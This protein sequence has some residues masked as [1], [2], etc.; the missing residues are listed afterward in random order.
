ML[1]TSTSIGHRATLSSYSN[2]ICVLLLNIC[3]FFQLRFRLH[4]LLRKLAG[5]ISSWSAPQTAAF[6]NVK[7]PTKAIGRVH[8]FK[9]SFCLLHV[10]LTCWSPPE[11][12]VKYLYT[13]C[14]KSNKLTDPTSCQGKLDRKEPEMEKW[15]LSGYINVVP[16]E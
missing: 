10:C 12:L 9:C 16:K 3:S 6:L 13:Q 11:E 4:Q 7:Y 1:P 14:Y 2:H 5:Y 15:K 8:C